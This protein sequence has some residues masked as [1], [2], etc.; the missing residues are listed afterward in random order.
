MLA[1]FTTL[2]TKMKTDFEK[3]QKYPVCCLWIDLRSS[4]SEFRNS[5]VFVF[6]GAIGFFLWKL[7]YQKSNMSILCYRVFFYAKFFS[8][9]SFLYLHPSLTHTLTHTHTHI[10]THSTILSLSLSIILSLSVH[11]ALS[12]SPPFSSSLYRSLCRFSFVSISFSLHIVS[13]TLF[14]SHIYCL[15]VFSL[16][17]Q[18]SVVA[19]STSLCG[20]LRSP[21]SHAVVVVGRRKCDCS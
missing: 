14:P 5:L 17:L 2:K 4:S 12:L 11:L 8:I 15:Y 3:V 7:V 21:V 10:H 9:F 6:A 16:F 13:F 18:F 1:G 20:H 19:D